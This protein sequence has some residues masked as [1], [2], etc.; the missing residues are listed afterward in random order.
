MIK[1]TLFM[2]ENMILGS[3]E[4]ISF[5]RADRFGSEQYMR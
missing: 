2:N 1:E 5:K 4:K 3:R